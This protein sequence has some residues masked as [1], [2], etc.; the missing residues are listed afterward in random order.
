MKE[1]IKSLRESNGHSRKEFAE[2]IGC[3][4]SH[5][6]NLETGAARLSNDHKGAL[7]D[8]FD[9][10]ENYF[11]QDDP[12][13][14]INTTEYDRIIGQ[15]IRFYRKQAGI[16][17]DILAQEM[18]YS[19]AS[20]ISAVERGSKPISKKKLIK[21]AEIFGIHVSEL[22]SNRNTVTSS[23]E[24]VLRNKFIFLLDSEKKPAVWDKIKELIETGCRE[25]KKTETGK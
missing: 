16:T 3:S 21:L 7:I 18:E 24:E 11:G 1:K 12:N 4:L 2:I 9:L 10:P 17:Q 13:A 20:S 14:P 15:N 23:E 5:V 6:I 8:H 22:F 19:Q 25:I